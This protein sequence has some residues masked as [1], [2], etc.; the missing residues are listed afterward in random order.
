MYI[1]LLHFPG[2]S[3]TF[4]E[5]RQEKENSFA[6][7]SYSFNI[8][9]GSHYS[10][11]FKALLEVCDESRMALLCTFI[12]KKQSDKLT[13]VNWSPG[14]Q[15]T[16]FGKHRAISSSS[17][18]FEIQIVVLV[19]RVFNRLK[20]SITDNEETFSTLRVIRL[21]VLCKYSV[22]QNILQWRQDHLIKGVCILHAYIHAPALTSSNKY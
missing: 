11:R 4:D 7:V 10:G 16:C 17:F 3:P 21:K 18:T 15:T 12:W 9:D 6:N 14:N 5:I 20:I 8:L 1:C 13:T 19:K 22:L 2:K